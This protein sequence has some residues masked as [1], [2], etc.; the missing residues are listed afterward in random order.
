MEVGAV[1]TVSTASSDPLSW[2]RR[3]ATVLERDVD[4]AGSARHFSAGRPGP[5]SVRS[6]V[7]ATL[8]CRSTMLA[9]AYLMCV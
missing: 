4:V 8:G 3:S 7:T 2:N 1:T 5:H 6:M 9:S